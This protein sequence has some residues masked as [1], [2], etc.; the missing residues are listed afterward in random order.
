MK[1]HEVR[2]TEE[3][4]QRIENNLKNLARELCLFKKATVREISVYILTALASNVVSYINIVTSSEDEKIFRSEDEKIF[5][6]VLNFFDEKVNAMVEKVLNE[7][8]TDR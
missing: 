6:D 7:R 1:S 5:R 3:C 8:K 4:A 2:L